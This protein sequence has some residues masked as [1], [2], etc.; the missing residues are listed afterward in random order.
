MNR[1]DRRPGRLALAGGIALALGL[2]GIAGAWVG[3]PGL[4]R[5]SVEL[6]MR[7]SSF[8]TGLIEVPLGVPVTIVLRNAD[9]IEH[10]WIVGDAASHQRHRTGTEPIHGARPTEASVPAGQ[11]RST[12]ITFTT[13]GDQVFVCHLP[14]HEAYGMVGTLRV[15]P[16]GE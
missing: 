1:S 2:A 13:A 9:P 12:T 7:Y 15:V 4:A 5:P 3:A 14:G 16:A 11:T 10:E 8:S 6:T